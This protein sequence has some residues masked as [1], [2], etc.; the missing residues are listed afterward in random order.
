MDT[1]LEARGQFPASFPDTFKN[2][3]AMMNEDED[4]VGLFA[5]LLEDKVIPR[6]NSPVQPQRQRYGGSMRSHSGGD[7][8]DRRGR[9]ERQYQQQIQ[10][11]HHH[12]QQ[13]QQHQQQQ[14]QQQG[15]QQ[16]RV[17]QSRSRSGSGSSVDL[18]A[19]RNVSFSTTTNRVNSLRRNRS[20]GSLTTLSSN[21][22]NALGLGP[23]TLAPNVSSSSSGSVLDLTLPGGTGTGTGDG[24]GGG[25]CGAQNVYPSPAKSNLKPALK[26]TN[27]SV[28]R[29]CAL[30]VGIDDGIQQLQQQLKN[31]QLGSGQKH[32]TMAC[33]ECVCGSGKAARSGPDGEDN[34]GA[35]YL[36]GYSGGYMLPPTP[37][38]K[39][40][41][42]TS[43]FTSA[44]LAASKNKDLQERQERQEKRGS[45]ILE[46]AFDFDASCDESDSISSS[47]HNPVPS[48]APHQLAYN[49]L[50]PILKQPQQQQ[51]KAMLQPQHQQVNVQQH[52]GV[53]QLQY[54]QVTHQQL[55]NQ[56]H[57]V[58]THQPHQQVTHQQHPGGGAHQQ[59]QVVAH[60]AHPHTQASHQ[61][62][63]LQVQLPTPGVHVV[64]RLLPTPPTHS[65]KGAYHT[66]ETALQRVQQQSGYY[67]QGPS[68]SASAY[69]YNQAM[70]QQQMQQQLHYDPHQ[71]LQFEQHQPHQSHQQHQQQQHQQQQHQ[72]QHQ[73][74][75][76][77]QQQHQQ[78]QQLQHQQQQ[79]QQQQHQQQHQ[80]QHQQYADDTELDYDTEWELDE[81]P[82]PQ[83]VP[84]LTTFNDFV[85]AAQN[86]TGSRQ[87]LR[88]QKSPILNRRRASS[89]A[90]N[91]L[92]SDYTYTRN[93]IGGAPIDSNDFQRISHSSSARDRMSLAGVLTFQQ[94]MSGAVS[95]Q[96]GTVGSLNPQPP[97]SGEAGQPGIV[98][99]DGIGGGGSSHNLNLTVGLGFLGGSSTTLAAV[100]EVTSGP[101][102]NGD[103]TDSPSPVSMIPSNQQKQQQQQ[104]LQ[105]QLQQ[106]QQH[107]PTH[108]PMK[109]ERGVGESSGASTSGTAIAELASSVVLATQSGKPMTERQRLRTSSMPAESR[110][111]RLAEM[112]RSAI[113]AGDPD[114]TYYRLR[115]FSI[116]SHGICNL[117]DSL[118]S[119]RSRSINSVTSTGTS[120]SGVDR[121][122]SNASGAS[123]EVIDGDPNVPAY[124]IAMLGASGVGKTTLTYQFTTSDYICAY[125]LSLDDDYGQKT[126]S[127]LVDNIET[128]LEIIDHPAC[129]MSTE[130]F[131]A[132]YNIDL[133]VVVY[134]VI[135]RNTFAAAERVLQYLKEN[136]MLL[137]RGAILVA[138]KT[139]LQRH[140]VVTRQ[141]GRKVAKEIA[142]K[143]IETSSGLDH[144]VDEL[145]VGI[146]AQVKLNPQRLR[147]LT[148]LELQR[149]NLQSTI[150][151][152]R[153]M[154]LQTR[155][156]VRQ[157]SVC[158]GDGEIFDGGLPEGLQNGEANDDPDGVPSTSKAGRSRI[159]NPNRKPLNLES[160]LKMGESEVD[161]DEDV[162]KSSQLSKFNMLAASIRH[163]RPFRKR[164]SFDGG[165][166]TSAAADAAAELQRRYQLRAMD[167]LQLEGRLAGATEE[168]FGERSGLADS[169]DEEDGEEAVDGGHRNA[170]NRKV[171]KKLT[172]RTKVFIS[173]VLRFKKAISL[174]RRNSSS[175]SD[176]FV[177]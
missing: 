173:S 129:E 19:N 98:G 106:E 160:I 67:N 140:R 139:D 94:A 83:I 158:Q 171:V 45:V 175:C 42:K 107:L 118:R 72:Q 73:Q 141:M 50:K 26:A 162:V 15:T 164:R 123:G 151:K 177:I 3:F 1:K 76:Q 74:Q 92:H 122:N 54:Q 137:S 154:H 65:G 128:D 153:G 16:Q 61:Q 84:P 2:F 78:H 127:V 12:Q 10:N 21:G 121:H 115:S 170:C 100:A 58:V 59:H 82:A 102:G 13:Q 148:E 116:T 124:K 132:T 159:E 86:P 81:E 96:Y 167:D 44:E 9:A 63:V 8:S 155:R 17:F 35:N 53:T 165:V 147:L 77:L 40:I 99:S 135:D 7:R 97:A 93:S 134:S 117:G 51:Q 22:L 119:R 111:P 110:R 149:L 57:Q 39:S 66:R 27:S 163:R 68:T 47:T 41:D 150:Q 29:G 52:Q 105:L 25:G 145:L 125:D 69:G 43:N 14:Q 38:G 172:A 56:Q 152:H 34:C 46:R 32:V 24:G 55:G 85:N 88:A 138:N 11:H 109:R 133:F 112:R 143:F 91:L 36:K 168:R 6:Q 131:C 79:H 37:K 174:K 104:L 20:R 166:S 157:M 126:V 60:Q 80:L 62:P 156:M 87:S 70:E 30:F 49:V 146:V 18:Y 103:S 28:D 23:V 75:Q 142:C 144:N 136:E 48:P 4:H 114:M 108:L 113:H 33:C 95:P 64:H 169:D 130:A 31:Q 120:N 101:D 89:I 71:E 5:N 161:E 90:G 176:L